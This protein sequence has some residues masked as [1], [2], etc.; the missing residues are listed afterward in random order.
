MFI[1]KTSLKTDLTQMRIDLEKIVSLIGWP[2][3]IDLE[4]KT[5]SSNQIGLN[6]RPGAEDQNLDN[7][8]SLM[9]QTIAKESDFT[10]FNDL[11]GT[12]TKSVIDHLAETEKINIGRIR[13]SLL[14]EKT[15]L[16]VHRDMEIRYHLA[17]YT[18]PNCFFGFTIDDE[19][20]SARCFNI[21]ADGF[22]Y[23]VDT[24]K[25]HFVYNGSREPRIH[26]V[27]CTY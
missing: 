5:I 22:F 23:R 12:Y 21:P 6:H 16:T 15:G 13:Y 14:E 9:R 20:I 19:N 17:L 24:N 7:V 11:I 3:K 2:K 8:G 10:E 4:G 27:I 25:E 1:E 18:N 26:L